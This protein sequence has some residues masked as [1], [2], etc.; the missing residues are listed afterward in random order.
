MPLGV[1]DV[2]PGQVGGEQRRLLAA[3][4]GLDLE[5]DVVGVV[6]VARRQQIGELGVELV[7]GGLQLGDLGGERLVVGGQLARGLQVAAGGL[8][9]A[10]GRNDRRDLGEP[11]ADPAGRGGVGVQAGIGELAL[12]VGVLGQQRVNRRCRVAHVA[13]LP[14][15]IQLFF[16]ER[17]PTPGLRSRDRIGRR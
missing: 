11:P 12:Q 9:L 1:A 5:H 8:Q 6:R 3:L 10:V 17:K 7:D 2:H 4:T 15:C 14:A 16:A 13:L